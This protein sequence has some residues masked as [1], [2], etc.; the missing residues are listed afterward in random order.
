MMDWMHNGEGLRV[1]N[2]QGL[3]DPD[4]RERIIAHLDAHLSK[5]TPEQAEYIGVDVDGPYKADNYR[6]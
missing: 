1:F 6:Y 3:S 2:L 4:D 5:L